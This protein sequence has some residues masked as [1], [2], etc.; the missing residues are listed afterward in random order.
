[1]WKDGVWNGQGSHFSIDEIDEAMNS[2]PLG[3][4]GSRADRKVIEQLD[5]I[6]KEIGYGALA[7]FADWLRDIRLYGEIEKIKQFKIQ[8][9][10]ELGW[11]LPKALES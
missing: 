8:R 9:F 5:E 1:M 6:G 4:V 11:E 7:Q 10:K 2:W 3:T